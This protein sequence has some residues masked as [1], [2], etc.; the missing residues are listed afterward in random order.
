[1]EAIVKQVSVSE[2]MIRCAERYIPCVSCTYALLQPGVQKSCGDARCRAETPRDAE[3]RL[4]H[5]APP[6]RTHPGCVWPGLNH[7]KQALSEPFVRVNNLAR[8][9]DVP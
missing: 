3:R 2:A 7:N 6:A 9:R 5:A 1:M 8:S 4:C